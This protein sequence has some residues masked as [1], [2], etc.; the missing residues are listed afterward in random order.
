MSNLEGATSAKAAS[1]SKKKI[2]CACPDTKVTV[3]TTQ[4]VFGVTEVSTYFEDYNITLP[5][6]GQTG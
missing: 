5:T 6:A 1:G 4:D 3:V 2:C